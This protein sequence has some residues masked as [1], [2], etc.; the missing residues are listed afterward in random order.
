[1]ATTTTRR[2]RPSPTLVAAVTRFP[3]PRYRLAAMCGVVDTT[4]AGW[5]SGRVR[6]RR[7]DSRLLRL[8]ALVGV[9]ESELWADAGAEDAA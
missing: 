6:P 2:S 8:A 3:L 5:L 1:M 7:D 4:L 9:S